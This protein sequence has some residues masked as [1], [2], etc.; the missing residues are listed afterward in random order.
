MQMATYCQSYA[1]VS[2]GGTNLIAG[3]FNDGIGGEDASKSN[4][5]LNQ[6]RNK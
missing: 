6:L 3:T 2:N 4:A 1:I 5:E